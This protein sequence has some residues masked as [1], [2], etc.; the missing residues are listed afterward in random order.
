MGGPSSRSAEDIRTKP[1]QPPHRVIEHQDGER[2]LDDAGAAAAHREQ[3]DRDGLHP[4]GA[5]NISVLHRSRPRSNAAKMKLCKL[6]DM[7]RTAVA[8]KS[9]VYR[10]IRLAR[11]TTGGDGRDDQQ[12]EYWA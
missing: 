5:R 2:A 9:E 11:R 8:Y 4:E 3:P 12:R 1:R 7:L 10:L 6:I